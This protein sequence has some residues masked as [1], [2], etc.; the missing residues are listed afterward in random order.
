MRSCIGSRKHEIEFS[1]RG[2]DQELGSTYRRDGPVLKGRLGLYSAT[3]VGALRREPTGDARWPGR[4]R[5]P[6]MR[7]R[8]NVVEDANPVIVEAPLGSDHRPRS[9]R[10]RRPVRIVTTVA[11]GRQVVTPHAERDLNTVPSSGSG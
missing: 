4:P 6:A 1:S 7:L 5:R 3:V 11:D 2:G 10:R 9:R 8:A